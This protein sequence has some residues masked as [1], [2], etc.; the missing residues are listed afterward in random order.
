VNEPNPILLL[1]LG[2]CC[3]VVG[4]MIGNRRGSVMVGF[5][6]GCILGPL[7]VLLACWLRKPSAPCPFCMEDVR[8]GHLPALPASVTLGRQDRGPTT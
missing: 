2:V 7:G 8:G 4:G 6:L 3:A 5:A 1:G